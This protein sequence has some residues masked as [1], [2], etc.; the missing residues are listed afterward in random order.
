MTDFRHGERER[1]LAR[2]AYQ[3]FEPLHL[4]AYFGPAVDAAR[5]RI[6]AGWLG[7]YTGMRAAPLGPVPAAVVAATFFG[8]S[9]DAVDRAWTRVLATHTTDELDAIR[10]ETVGSA[11]RECLGDLAATPELARQAARMREILGAAGFG[12]RPLAAAYAALPWP[13]APHL[14][15]WHATAVWREWRGDGHN[16]VLLT[17][18]LAPLEAL[19]LYDASLRDAPPHTAVGRD[20]SMLQPSRR[21]SDDEWL[22]AAAA[23]EDRGLVAVAGDVT[24]VTDAGAA[25]RQHIEDATD[26][27]AASVWVDVP[28]AEAVLGAF[29]PFSK[30]VIRAGILP[31]TTRRE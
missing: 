17:C 27:A 22:T 6:D 20:R 18:G 9:P 26:D 28:D 23:L 4:V 31:G 13:E 7:S 30:A 21:W 3:T 15:L 1:H 24:T 10:T 2:L 19:V 5:V 16:A 11:L 25:L 12:G 29:R 14:A 8:F